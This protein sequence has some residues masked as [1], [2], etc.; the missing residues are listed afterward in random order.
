MAR[1]FPLVTSVNNLLWNIKHYRPHHQRPP[2]KATRHPFC[3]NL[4]LRDASCT[5]W[6]QETSRELGLKL[7]KQAQ[8]ATG[9]KPAT[10]RL[11]NIQPAALHAASSHTVSQKEQLSELEIHPAEIEVVKLFQEGN[12]AAMYK[13]LKEFKA[14][15]VLIP[16]GIINEM[17]SSV[18]ENVPPDSHNGYLHQSTVEEPMFHGKNN[19]RLASLYSKVYPHLDSLYNICKLYENEC[20]ANTAFL[21]NYIWLCYHTEDLSTLQRL[22]YQYS[23]SPLYDS[24]TLSYVV[25]AFVYN[26]DIEFAKSLFHSIVGMQKPLDESFLASTVVSFVKARALFDN[27]HEIFKCWTTSENCES[28]YPKTVALLLKQYHTFGNESEIALMEDITEHLGYNNNFLV[29]MVKTQTAILNRDNNIKK[30]ITSEDL[31][32]ILHLRN[33]L[34]HSKYALKVYYESYLR[35]FA[36]YS[37]MGVTQLILKEMRKDGVPI[38]RA[39]Y[40]TIIRHYAKEGKFTSLY[41]FVEKFVSKS[42]RFELQYVKTIF[43]TFVKTYPY[44]GE[45]FTQRLYD[46][47]E[48]TNNLSDAMKQTLRDECKIVRVNSNITPFA[49]QP[50]TF[51]NEKKFGP[52]WKSIRHEPGKHFKASQVKDQIR[53]RMDQ[54][55]LDLMRR[56]VMPDYYVLENTLRNLNA[57][58]RKQILDSLTSLRLQKHKTRLELFDFFLA[59]PD[60]SQYP[61][62]VEKVRS[63][64]STSDRLLLARRVLNVNA[65]ELASS[66]LDAVNVSELTESRPMFVLNLQLR[67]KLLGNKFDELNQTIKDFPVNDVT[68]SPYISKQCRYIEKNIAKKI[69]ALEAKSECALFSRVP[70]MKVALETLRGLI[71]DIDARIKKDQEDIKDIIAEL[72]AMLDRWIVESRSQDERRL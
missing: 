70:E 10:T 41:K 57:S 60:R 4:Q 56:G 65:A 40:D 71:G 29:Q 36:K 34:S 50:T 46:W 35:F 55:L 54:G 14:S 16:T 64:L 3:T 52:Q 20:I 37:T 22:F 44:E 61:A 1:P 51:A 28:P 43:D 17:I 66:L 26:Y 48:Q 15:G 72:F 18:H 5:Y 30:S 2:F 49:L 6:L 42:N 19:L 27:V 59:H 32:K 11:L 8:A 69:K 53:F 12:F 24:R 23:K 25:N 38:T 63:R 68:L 62:F 58:V 39:S 67:S 47:I 31:S 45:M 13:R 9:H 33:S 7:G 21:Q